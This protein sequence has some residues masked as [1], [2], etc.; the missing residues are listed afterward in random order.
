M[1]TGAL[2]RE[3]RKNGFSVIAG[4]DEVGR[5]PLAG[6]VV[7]AAVVLPEQPRLDGLTDSKKLTPKQRQS[8]YE[9]IYSQAVTVGI[10]IVDPPEIERLNILRAS[11]LAM[12]LAL[13]NLSP[14]PDFLLIDGTFPIPSPLPQ[15]AVAKGDGLSR[16]IAAA[17]VVAK[18]SRDRIMERYD[19]SYPQYGFARHKGYGT[20]AHRAAIA[21]YGCCP[22]HRRRFKG[23][24]EYLQPSL[25]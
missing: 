14:I 18:V 12:G 5:G 6:P 1:A 24:R 20:R 23:V 16:S 2:E 25:F 9:A 21:R 22:I 3:A 15:Q 4:L 8:L 11:L 19:E 7:S 17:S 13:D 10:A